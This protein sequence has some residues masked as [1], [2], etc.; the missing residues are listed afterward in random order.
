MLD[1]IV[2]RSVTRLNATG[3]EYEY[4]GADIRVDAGGSTFSF[5]LAGYPL[6]GWAGLSSLETAMKLVDGWLDRS[7]GT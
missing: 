3:N 1:S 6:L 7:V 5:T 2:D 4:R